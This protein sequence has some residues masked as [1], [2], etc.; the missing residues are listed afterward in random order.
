MYVQ[1]MN[2]QPQSNNIFLWARK[3]S[4]RFDSATSFWWHSSCSIQHPSA[5][6]TCGFNPHVSHKLPALSVSDRNQLPATLE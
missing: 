4:Q 5:P 2:D 1:C 3:N 6:P